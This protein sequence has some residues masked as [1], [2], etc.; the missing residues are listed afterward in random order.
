MLGVREGRLTET[1]R[2]QRRRVSG[3]RGDAGSRGAGAMRRATPLAKA[4]AKARAMAMAMAMAMAND[5]HAPMPS[6]ESAAHAPSFA[7]PDREA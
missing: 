3:R 6:R 2:E 5:T 4:R 7:A 1:A